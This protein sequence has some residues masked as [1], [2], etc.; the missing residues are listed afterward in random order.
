[1]I[2]ENLSK[3]GIS[4]DGSAIGRKARRSFVDRI[5]GFYGVKRAPFE[6]FEAYKPESDPR[7]YYAYAIRYNKGYT[8]YIS[9][10]MGHNKSLYPDSDISR[11]PSVIVR[12]DKTGEYKDLIEGYG[13]YYKYYLKQDILY[14]SN[15]LK[16]YLDNLGIDIIKDALLPKYYTAKS[17]LYYKSLEDKPGTFLTSGKPGQLVC[18]LDPAECNG[19][20]TFYGRKVKCRLYDRCK[21][22]ING[23]KTEYEYSC[24][25]DKYLGDKKYDKYTK[26]GARLNL[27]YPVF[28]ETKQEE[29][30][31]FTKRKHCRIAFDPDYAKKYKQ[32]IDNATEKDKIERSKNREDK[33]YEKISDINSSTKL[34]PCGEDCD[35]CP[36]DECIYDTD[37]KIDEVL[38]DIVSDK[39]KKKY[40]YPD[41]RKRY[42]ERIKSDPVLYEKY[43]EAQRIKVKDRRTLMKSDPE[44]YAEYLDKARERYHNRVNNMSEDEL[45]EFKARQKI[46]N[47]KHREKHKML[48]A[49]DEEYARKYK[50]AKRIFN[51]SYH[52]R[53]YDNLSAEQKHDR[54]VKAKEHINDLRKDPEYDAKFKEYNNRKA[55]QYRDELKDRANNGDAEAIKKIETKRLN[56]KQKYDKMREFIKNNPEYDK[57]SKEIERMRSA[58]RRLKDT[59]PEKY[60]ILITEYNRKASEFKRRVREAMKEESKK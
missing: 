17:Y 57:K 39:P 34:L 10:G 29:S 52:K 50:E 56:A 49:T 18:I 38:N 42:I 41:S 45:S 19:Y 1:M 31:R 37:E 43:K 11:D 40:N 4:K 28:R 6:D 20:I 7:L 26:I 16:K 21:A 5:Y 55:K 12:N 15:E 13:K 30:S 51:K 27:G 22:S 32:W 60:R 3:Y 47:T 58:T 25:T 59:E 54:Y 48:M 33:Y 2:R 35:N 23:K 44:W 8:I 9:N 24:Y 14:I 53:Y 46:R 36:Y